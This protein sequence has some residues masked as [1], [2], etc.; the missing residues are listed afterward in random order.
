MLGPEVWLDYFRR[1]I[2]ALK[3]NP[4]RG[5]NRVVGV[6]AASP[7]E[8]VSKIVVTDVR[9]NNELA[10]FRDK[11]GAKLLYVNRPQAAV[12]L[13]SSVL[14]HASEQDQN[15]FDLSKFD[16]IVNNHGTLEELVVEATELAKTY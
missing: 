11:L 16:A 3:E 14:N 15:G 13:S 1:T 10:Y 9:F 4:G 5:Y 7:D 6:C 12:N 2:L 8:D